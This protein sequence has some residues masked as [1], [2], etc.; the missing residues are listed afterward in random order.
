LNATPLAARFHVVARVC[1]VTLVLLGIA[2]LIGWVFDVAVLMQVMPT[3][4]SMKPNTALLFI[5]L[6]V[7]L[8]IAEDPTRRTLRTGLGL[9]IATVSALTLLEY[10][11]ALDLGIDELLF[12]DPQND[13]PNVPGRMSIVTATSFL[14]FGVAVLAFDVPAASR[15]REAAVLVAACNAF[16]VLCGYLFGVSQ[17]YSIFTYTTVALHTAIGFL[18]ATAAYALSPSQRFVGVLASDTVAGRLLRRL[19]PVTVVLPVLVGAL[20]LE[21]QR[22]GASSVQFGVSIVVLSIVLSL[23][24]VAWIVAHRLYRSEV[25]ECSAYDE[26]AARERQ[27]SET[28]EAVRASEARNCAMLDAA[29]DAVVTV[30]AQGQIVGFNPAAERMF[31]YRREDVLGKALIDC[32][33]PNSLFD[34]CRA[35]FAHYRLTGQSN[36]F[37]RV[38]ELSARRADGTEFPIELAVVRVPGQDP[39][40]FIGHIRDITERKRDV[41]RFRLALEAAPTGMLLIDGA[42]TIVLVNSQIERQFGY[43]RTALLGQSMEILVP[44]RYRARHPTFRARYEEAPTVR[45]MGAGRELFGLRSDDTEFPVEIGLTPIETS[46]GRVVLASIVDIT[47]RRRA[48]DERSRLVTEL[49]ILTQELEQRVEARTR[50]VRERELRYRVLFNESPVA[51]CEKDYSAALAFVRELGP[52]EQL[53]ERLAAQPELV[54]AALS[55]VRI[56][57]VNRRGLELFGANTVSELAARWVETFG[58]DSDG[59]LGDELLAVLHGWSHFEIEGPRRTLDGRLVHLRVQVTTL[60]DTASVI[61]SMVDISASKEAEQALR[62]SMGRQ[63][64]L[65]R[66]IHHRVKNNLAV[67]ASLFYFESM[68]TT[69]ARAVALFEDSRRRIRSMALVH[70]TLYRSD[71]LAS[72]DMADYARILANEVMVTCQKPTTKVRLSTDLQPVSLSIDQAVP[73]GLILNE[74]VCNAFKH[75]FPNGRSGR[76]HVSIQESGVNCI[77]RVID[78]GVGLPT[79]LD[80]TTHHSLGLRL[81]RLLAKQ[82]RATLEFE[83]RRPGTEGRVTFARSHDR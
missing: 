78:D 41:E 34:V 20:M 25:A 79:D 59:A 8:L 68:H 74:L 56:L 65:L 10:A 23:G 40:L 19:L 27:I 73:C 15:L 31:D 77:M 4:V 13:A 50:E 6:G 30:D 26:L 75:A 81:V 51:M 47:E 29:F 33:I 9:A 1:A 37:G 7:A 54:E 83:R 45:A 28:L 66:E 44:H 11:F 43:R 67:I 35:G 82:L 60:P 12:R 22:V 70:E 71:N 32:I 36:L 17:L 24:S 57:D 42:G 5:L 62:E 14:L 48:E 49:R 21:W 63:E 72:I 18:V 58:T 69:D 61:V 64:V 80:I 2:V 76:V 3:L 39:P 52:V 16:V 55:N 53:S 46:H 38:V